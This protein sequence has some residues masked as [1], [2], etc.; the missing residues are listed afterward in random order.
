MDFSA[1]LCLSGSMPW[2]KKKKKK[3]HEVNDVLLVLVVTCWSR[4]SSRLNPVVFW[5]LLALA[6]SL[7]CSPGCTPSHDWAF[8]W[9]LNGPFITPLCQWECLA[10][11]WKPG[12]NKH[13]ANSWLWMTAGVSSHRDTTNWIGREFNHRS[14]WRSC[15]SRSSSEW[16]L[17][18]F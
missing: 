5:C 18:S 1:G 4:V 12:K 8:T 16:L 11:S 14:R 10:H 9:L 17:Y 7:W 15:R 6:T 3:E 2:V 13:G